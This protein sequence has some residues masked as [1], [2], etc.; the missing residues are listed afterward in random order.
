MDELIFQQLQLLPTAQRCRSQTEKNILE[1]LFSEVLSQFKK[2]HPSL[3]LKFNNL[4]TV[5]S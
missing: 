1:D 4:N 5:Q 2:Y 3:N